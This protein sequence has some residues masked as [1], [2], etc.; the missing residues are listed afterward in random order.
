MSSWFARKRKR[1]LKKTK[2][3]PKPNCPGGSKEPAS[4]PF[5]QP[6]SHPASSFARP[7][8]RPASQPEPGPA[9]PRSWAQGGPKVRPVSPEWT[10]QI[11]KR[12][13]LE[14]K[15]G[16][17]SRS[18]QESPRSQP[19]SHSAR[20]STISASSSGPLAGRP[21]RQEPDQPGLDPGHKRDPEC[22]RCRAS[23]QTLQIPFGTIL[24]QN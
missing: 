19:V 24:S 14:K 4:Q 11:Q 7:A 1:T 22:V 16:S 10:L 23:E 8:G 17:Q 15:K 9:R 12:A 3:V 13:D 6:F 18:V 21:A 5:N 2:R 20:Q